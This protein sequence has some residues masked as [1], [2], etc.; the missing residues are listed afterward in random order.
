[1]GSHP[2]QELQEQEQGPH[3]TLLLSLLQQQHLL[4]VYVPIP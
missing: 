1:M 3:S 4:F 2:Q